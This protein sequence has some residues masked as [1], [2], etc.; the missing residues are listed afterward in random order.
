MLK[1]YRRSTRYE[2][3]NKSSPRFLAMHELDTTSVAPE[4]KYVMGTTL[5]KKMVS[6]A[7]FAGRDTWEL[8]SEFGK[9]TV[10]EQF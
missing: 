5:A 1:G 4:I 8:I 3:L 7:K 10:G 6:T 2:K 9:G